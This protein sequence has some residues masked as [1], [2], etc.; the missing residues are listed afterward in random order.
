MPASF[1]SSYLFVEVSIELATAKRARG[2]CVSYRCRRRAAKKK[3]GRCET[4][5]SRLFRLKDDCRYAYNNLKRSAAKRGIP[6]DLPFDIFE[7]FCATTGY[8][9]MRGKEPHSYSIDRIDTNGPYAWGNIRILTY[10]DNVSH[11][12]E[13]A[14]AKCRNRRRAA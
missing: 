1:P 3:G 13:D 2:R 11:K 8:L 4:C 10:M 9:E 6:F 5:A 12:Y 7:D 14:A